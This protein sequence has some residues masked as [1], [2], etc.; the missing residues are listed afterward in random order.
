MGVN[1]PWRLTKHWSST[2]VACVVDC[3][4]RANTTQEHIIALN[5]DQSQ[6]VSGYVTRETSSSDTEVSRTDR[7]RL[8]RERDWTFQRI[9]NEEDNDLFEKTPISYATNPR[10]TSKL[11]TMMEL[12]S[13]IK[14]N[15][16]DLL[17]PVIF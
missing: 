5:L 14:L 16:L 12:Y 8:G 4:T 7:S 13:I 1:T 10:Q 2:L 11:S 3:S 17:Y 9:T 15:L 6:T